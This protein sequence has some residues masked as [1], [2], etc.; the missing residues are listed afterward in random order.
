MPLKGTVIEPERDT[1][2]KSPLK[3]PVS[4]NVS[5]AREVMFETVAQNCPLAVLASKC[6]GVA[7]IASTLLAEETAA[8]VTSAFR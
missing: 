3:F 1:A 5:T 8:M 4:V 2:E 6:M 7:V